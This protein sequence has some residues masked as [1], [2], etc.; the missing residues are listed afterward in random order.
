MLRFSAL[1][2]FAAIDIPEIDRM[3]RAEWHPYSVAA[4]WPSSEASG[5][6]MHEEASF[7]VFLK[8]MGPGTWS[9]RWC[10]KVGDAPDLAAAIDSLGPISIEGPYGGYSP[11]VLGEGPEHPPA[12][13]LIAGGIGI[14]PLASMLQSL[15]VDDKSGEHSGDVHLWWT[16]RYH[17]RMISLVNAL[18]ALTAAAKAL[19]PRL[20]MRIFVTSN[21]GMPDTH[22]G[23]GAESE[24]S[25]LQGSAVAGNAAPPVELTAAMAVPASLDRQRPNFVQLFNELRENIAVAAASA[26]GAA[27]S[28][29]AVLAVPVHVCG[30]VQMAVRLTSGITDAL[31]KPCSLFHH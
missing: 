26:G 2:K 29:D 24:T 25:Q 27:T 18:P 4:I 15:A 11:E 21:E 1:G 8:D 10:Q 14:T 7:D 31:T 3:L 22:A 9:S 28:P 16:C 5:E 13:V 23:P 20:H 17:E 12:S 6:L 19:G 30:P